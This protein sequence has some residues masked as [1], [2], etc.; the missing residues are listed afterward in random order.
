MKI[1]LLLW[2]VAFLITILTA[3]YQRVTGPT[4]PL[5][6]KIK[7]SGKEIDYKL[8]RS[9]GG[10]GDQIVKIKIP[11]QEIKGSLYYKRYKTNDSYIEVKMQYSNGELKAGLPH[12]PPAGKLEYYIKLYNKQ[13]VIHLPENRSVVTRFKGH[14]SLYVL[15]PH[16]LFMFTAM[17]LSVR[18]GLEIFN[19]ESNYKKLTYWT[20]AILFLGGLILGPIVQYYAFGA[21][22]TGVPF[23]WDLTDNKTLIAM[24]GWLIALFM[25][26]RSKKPKLWAV[27]ASLLLLVVYLIP[28]SVL[29]SE[30][31]YNK[32]NKQSKQSIENVKYY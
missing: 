25:Y 13:N 15:I 9:H 1:K 20:I 4:Y 3:Y 17:L 28:H 22:W 21:F 30:L 7:F 16:I 6:G 26:G 11:D 5:K 19:K 32:L 23:G 29:G 18:T 10:N 2:I 12:Q 31:D 8:D 14:I 24:L 27:Y